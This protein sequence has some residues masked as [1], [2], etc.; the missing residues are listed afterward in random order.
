MYREEADGTRV[1]CE[2]L[3]PEN[4]PSYL[5]KSNS[6]ENWTGRARRRRDTVKTYTPIRIFEGVDRHKWPRTWMLLI[7][8]Y[9][10]KDF[11]SFT[12]WVSDDVWKQQFQPPEPIK[13][14][15]ADTSTHTPSGE[16][17]FGTYYWE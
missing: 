10:L 13:L 2:S 15:P 14:A 5:H 3:Y 4:T 9:T 7:R 6:N 11:H 12:R 1:A 16:D 8:L 17:E